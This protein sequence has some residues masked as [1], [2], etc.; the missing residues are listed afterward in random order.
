MH[1]ASIAESILKIARKRLTETRNAESVV[2]VRVLVGEF[3]NV[4]ADSLSFAFDN[5]KGL[6]TGCSNC[7]LE[8]EL[9]PLLAYCQSENHKYSPR[10]E[11]AYRCKICGSGIGKLI[12]GDE[13]DI[14]GVTLQ[15]M[16]MAQD[17]TV[18][19]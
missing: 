12:A 5:L 13:L 8:M 16:S 14:V 7:K 17:K 3:R 4:E 19:A 6:Y 2:S 18:R 1:E 15:A 11:D 9:V 10:F